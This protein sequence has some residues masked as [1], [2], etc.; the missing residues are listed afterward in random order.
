MSVSDRLK[1]VIINKQEVFKIPPG[2]RMLLRRCCNA[3]YKLENLKNL[4]VVSIILV[5]NN[6]IQQL[7][8]QYRN[9]DVPT[10]VLSFSTKKNG[11]YD[12]DPDTGE[13]VLGDIIISIEKVIE[14]AKI[15]NHD[16]KRE[17]TYLT[18]HGMLHLLG[19]DHENV[20]EK[21]KMREKEEIIMD[22]LGLY[23]SS[24]QRYFNK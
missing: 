13:I 8:K 6:Y 18:V 21:V 19:Y 10:D 23:S 12:I 5:D 15:Y 7:N 11:S 20:F 22:Q 1:V 16:K 3:I 14:Q 17:L 2:I 9:K 24:S 4:T